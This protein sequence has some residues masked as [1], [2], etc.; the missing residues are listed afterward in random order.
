MWIRD[1]ARDEDKLPSIDQLDNPEHFPYRWGQALWAYVAGRWGDSIVRQMLDEA[2]RVGGAHRRSSACLASR[3]RAVRAVARGEFGAVR[4]DAASR[5]AREHAGRPLTPDAKRGAWRSSPSL[6]PDGRHVV[7]L[8]ERDMLS[9]D[10][11]LA[12]AETGRIVGAR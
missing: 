7:Y 1:A 8:S 2:I 12:D 4:A 6:S 3:R 9:I 10:I 5:H 11:Y